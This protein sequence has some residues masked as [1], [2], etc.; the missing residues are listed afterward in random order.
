MAKI[1]KGN[2]G[3]VDILTLMVVGIV[4]LV[5]VG[6][7]TS[8]DDPRFEGERVIIQGVTYDRNLLPGSNMNVNW[9][10]VHRGPAAVY[11]IDFDIARAGFFDWIGG[12]GDVLQRIEVQIGVNDDNDFQPYG[13][14]KSEPFNLGHGLYMPKT[15]IRSGN[16]VVAEQVG[17]GIVA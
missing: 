15:Y 7:I 16:R 9:S 1:V 2:P 4:G 11:T 3:M 10:F 14:G 6:K 5:V 13:I 17:A 12:P 8:K